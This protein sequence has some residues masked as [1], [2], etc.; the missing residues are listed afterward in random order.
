MGLVDDLAY[1]PGDL[2]SITGGDALPSPFSLI[3]RAV[4]PIKIGGL[5][6]PKTTFISCK[7]RKNIVITEIPGGNGTV[8]EQISHPDYEFT[9]EGIYAEKN[10]KAVL[11][12]LDNLAALWVRKYSLPILCPLTERLTVKQVALQNFEIGPKKGFPSVIQFKFDAIS[13]NSIDL[14]K[15]IRNGTFDKLRKLVGI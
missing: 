7:A 8:K 15:E 6:L 1:S 10:N 14:K 4:Y 11:Q 13:D 12:A 2:A 9:I 3:T 5:K